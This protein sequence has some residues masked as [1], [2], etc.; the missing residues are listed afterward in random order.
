MR[1]STKIYI[2]VFE[3]ELQNSFSWETDFFLFLI[4]MT[5]SFF[6]EKNF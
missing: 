1:L 3:K 2:T 5:V 6:L 4:T